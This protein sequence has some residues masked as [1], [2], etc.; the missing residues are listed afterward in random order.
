MVICKNRKCG[1]RYE[2]EL[3]MDKKDFRVAVIDHNSEKCPK[4]GK[5]SLYE[6]ED[7]FFSS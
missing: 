2:S 6:K 5:H 4:C 7:Y 3:Q 1:S